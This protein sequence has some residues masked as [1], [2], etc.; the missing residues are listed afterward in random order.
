MRAG[1]I[2]RRVSVQAVFVGCYLAGIGCSLVVASSAVA[3]V[4]LVVA[5]VCIVAA[6]MWRL[7]A[8]RAVLL[9]A[10]GFTLLGLAT[11]CL[12]LLALGDSVL[13]GAAGKRV[14]LDVTVL[15][16]PRQKNGKIS[17]IGLAQGGDYRGSELKLNE[18]VLVELYCHEDCAV[19]VDRF[20]EGTRFHVAGSLQT[21]RSNQGGDFDYS[22]YLARRGI[23]TIITSQPGDIRPLGPRGGW[24]GL[25]DSLRRHSRE[26]LE[27]GG[28]GTATGLLKG[29]VLGDT[30]DVPDPVID[31]LRDAGL[32]HLLAV[33]GQN[34]VLLGFVIMIICR[35]LMLS[36]RVA[37]A[38]AITAVCAYVP[39]TGADPSI[40]RAG[41]VG[42]LGLVAM[43]FGRRAPRFYL[44]A[45][46]AAVLLTL[47]PNYLL[48]PGFQLSYAA[49]LS[50]FLVAPSIVRLLGFLP[51]LLA[52]VAAVSA[53]AG[54]ATAPITLAHFQQVS[55]VTI[56]AN[57]AAAPVAGPVMFLGTLAI[58]AA[59]VSQAASRLISLAATACTGYLVEVG[60]YF[61]S[62]PAAVYV[63][64]APSLVV[65]L[66]FYAM[67]VAVAA[68]VRK[69]SWQDIVGRLGRSKLWVVPAAI[70]LFFLGA[71]CFGSPKADPPG[72]YTVSFLDVGQG[73]ATLI[74]VPGGAT[75]LVD[76]GP[77]SSVLDRLRE[78]GV[79]RIDAMVLSHPHADHVAGLTLVLEKYDVGTVY[80]TA[81]P[82]TSPVYADFLR[83]IERKDIPYV[84]MRAGD[85]L[86]FGELALEAFSP[87]DELVPDDIN[88]NSLVLVASYGDMDVL[89]PGDAEG[90]I[91][92]ALGLPEVEGLKV[93]HHG[94]SD[95]SLGQLLAA[96]KP[97]VAV[98]SVG[99]GNDY[100]HPAESTL[101]KL[102][103][104]RVSSYRT[105][106][107][108]TVRLSLADGRMV[109]T[110]AN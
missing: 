92:S 17:L 48:E 16:A 4:S 3:L 35:A 104:A 87:G 8:L 20:S 43:L 90:R 6:L 67:L 24:A 50:I 82:S 37:A 14:T 39:L 7:G 55:L 109:V 18:K 45:V 69:I 103:D 77:G 61:A 88:A 40:L 58:I 76:G 13:A 53:A 70:F 29:M 15:R 78:S 51:A 56:P 105:D 94:S 26:S 2:W 54:L 23:H 27:A 38:A 12:R 66:L 11:G 46:S 107:D 65:I 41:T 100:G 52:E 31:D 32:L 19:A 75:V 80:D 22:Q 47:N 83:A 34:V 89:L 108:G 9:V 44:L 21:P 101:D 1:N 102:K 73:D 49:V 81:A 97:Q 64:T 68:V 96:L 28:H 63:G 74:Q 71:A 57:V 99:T 62:L 110:T 85:R 98:I 95:D 59:P 25:V 10:C 79:D 60:G 91:L 5:A 72:T 84:P 86:D 36:R 33:S 42:V 106:R 93:S 30:S